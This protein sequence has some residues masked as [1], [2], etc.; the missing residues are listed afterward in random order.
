MEASWLSAVT[1]LKDAPHQCSLVKYLA[2]VLKGLPSLCLILWLLIDM[3][4]E[5]KGSLPQFVKQ[6]QG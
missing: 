2:K 4:Y 3:C 1:M 6:W 5:N